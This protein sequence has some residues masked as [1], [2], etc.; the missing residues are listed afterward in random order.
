MG[1]S[2]KVISWNTQG[3]AAEKL[4]ALAAVISEWN[5]EN[6]PC[7]IFIYEGGP[8]H[9][10][11][12]PEGYYFDVNNG[13]YSCIY[14]KAEGV[15]IN[16]RCTTYMFTNVDPRYITN[17]LRYQ[18]GTYREAAGIELN[19]AIRIYGVHAIANAG[20]SVGQIRNLIREI[21]KDILPWMFI[22]DFNA[23]PN[24]FLLP[25]DRPEKVNGKQFSDGNMYQMQYYGSHDRGQRYCHIWVPDHETQGANGVRTKRLDFFF[26]DH[27]NWVN[28]LDVKN[29]YMKDSNNNHLSDHNLIFADIFVGK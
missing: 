26:T 28:V 29:I 4:S 8:S 5:P 9:S 20:E 19:Q 17:I 18:Y 3:G 24:N 11:G 12:F 2:M 16:K 22:G 25:N 27:S 14:V 15:A 6:E 21:D 7:V 10:T 13:R 1:L 23:E